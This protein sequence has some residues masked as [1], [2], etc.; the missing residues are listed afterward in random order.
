MRKGKKHAFTVF[1]RNN[2]LHRDQEPSLSLLSLTHT[3]LCRL[4]AYGLD[5]V[6]TQMQGE[7]WSPNGEARPLLESLKL[8]HTSMSVGDV[9]LDSQGRYFA[10]AEY[11]WDEL[12]WEKE[13]GQA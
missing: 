10:C 7:T 13:N 12:N 6:Y 11:G 5:D 9:V 2:N 3:L 8:F 1:Y 4:R